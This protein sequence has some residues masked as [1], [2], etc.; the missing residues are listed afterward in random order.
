[1]LYNRSLL[2]IHL[3]Y[4]DYWLIILYF[5]LPW[6]LSWLKKKK[7]A[8]NAGDTGSISGSGRSAGEGISYP[9]QYSCASLVAQ[10]IKNLPAMQET[11][12]LSLGWE[13]PLEKG[14]T[15][16]SSVLA[17]RIPGTIQSMESQS[18]TRLNDLHIFLAIFLLRRPKFQPWLYYL[19]AFNFIIHGY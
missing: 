7:C 11:W 10:M 16:H 2:V 1:M 13:D 17:W 15:T 14:K 12:V 5:G 18:R 9:L 3:K 4:I 19:I 8:C 6:Y